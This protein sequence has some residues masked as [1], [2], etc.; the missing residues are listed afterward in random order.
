VRRLTMAAAVALMC[1]LAVA[2]VW[3]Q[4]VDVACGLYRY[5][6]TLR[7]SP[8]LAEGTGADNN[9]YPAYLGLNECWTIL[10]QRTTGEEAPYHEW[11]RL[12]YPGLS[13]VWVWAGG[14]E[15]VTS[16]P[17][18]TIPGPSPTAE[19]SPVTMTATQVPTVT[20]TAAP[21]TPMAP[22][23]REVVRWRVVIEVIQVVNE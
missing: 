19:A 14:V 22:P 5:G 7:S 11:L 1:L 2:G 12:D 3:A 20:P 8:G 17:V 18:A 23:V 4:G 10:E 15:V 13:P 21:P 9:A 6:V 16:A